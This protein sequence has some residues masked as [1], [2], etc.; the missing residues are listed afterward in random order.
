VYQILNSLFPIFAVIVFGY[1]AKHYKFL[2][3][4]FWVSCEKLAYYILL[5]AILFINISTAQYSDI[6]SYIP[7][8]TISLISISLLIVITL[9]GKYI[10]NIKNVDF[11][12]FLQGSVSVNAAYIG[13][14]ASYAI[15]GQEGFIAYSMILAI[16]VPFVNAVTI[17]ILG[18]YAHE[19][20]KI[21]KMVLKKI[22]M[23]PVINSC[24][25]GFLFNYFDIILPKPIFST[26]EIFSKAS[27]PI[28]L[29]I[30]GGA[31]DIKSIRGSW[32]YINSAACLKLIISPII[33]I[34]LVKWFGMTGIKANILV[35][36][37]ALP[38][39]AWTYLMSKKLKGNA[40]LMAGMIVF[41]TMLALVTMTMMLYFAAK[42]VN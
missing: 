26:V 18:I 37:A 42:F 15:F 23:H 28:G 22:T 10:F 2:S 16:V 32:R 3:G 27:V 8:L 34:L 36:Y 25:I 40:E 21:L 33:A 20:E 6:A 5:P 35:L 29:I 24:A 39:A 30:V 13:I 4:E 14:P 19:D 38:T 17:I 41:E 31:L 11:N 12:A 9:A 7:M 1:V